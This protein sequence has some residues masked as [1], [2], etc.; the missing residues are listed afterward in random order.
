MHEKQYNLHGTRTVSVLQR[1]TGAV[2]LFLG[3]WIFFVP[4]VYAGGMAARRMQMQRAIMQQQQQEMIQQQMIQ[5]QQEMVRQEMIRRRQEALKQQAIMQQQQ[6]MRQQIAQQQAEAY[7]AAQQKKALM[8]M[9]AVKEQKA[10]MQQKVNAQQ[11]K[12]WNMPPPQIELEGRFFG[13]P[14]D[15]AEVKGETTMRDIMTA[16]DFSSKVWPLIIDEEIKDMVIAQHIKKYQDQG[17][18]LRL[19]AFFYRDRID[20]MSEGSPEMLQ[21]PIEQILRI[22]AIIEYDFDNGEDKEIMALKVLGPQMY[23]QNKERILSEGL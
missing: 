18:I 20:T 13:P 10:F 4:D 6:A 9:Q 14:E 5:R 22:V 12:E 1:K 16:F 8:Q 21:Q 19:P 7:Q 15:N 3:L 23:Q 17:V 11:Y 2:L